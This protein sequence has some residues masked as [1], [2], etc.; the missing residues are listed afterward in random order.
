MRQKSDYSYETFIKLGPEVTAY[1]FTKYMGMP[2]WQVQH[3]I[4]MGLVPSRK[5]VDKWTRHGHRVMVPNPAL[6]PKMRDAEWD[7]SKHEFIT[8]FPGLRTDGMMT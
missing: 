2:N 6:D 7:Q 3:L 5:V 1:A 4:K 8:L